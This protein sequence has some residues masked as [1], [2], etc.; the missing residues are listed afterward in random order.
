MLYAGDPDFHSAL[1]TLGVAVLETIFEL[2]QELGDG[3]QLR[4]RV[5]L[6]RLVKPRTIIQLKTQ[7][8]IQLVA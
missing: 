5:S 4:A 3:K 6:C 1:G 2:L 7:S 8:T